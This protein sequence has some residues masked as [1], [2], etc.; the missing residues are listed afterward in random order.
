MNMFRN[1]AAAVAVDGDGELSE[2][3]DLIPLSHLALDLPEPSEGWLTFLGRRGIRFVSD[4]LGRDAIS[5]G[6][7]QRLLAEKREAELRKRQLAAQQ[8]AE[9]VLKDQQFRAS[10]PKGL[11]WYAFDGAPYG[12][13][14][15]AAEAAQQPRRTPSRGEWLFG[16]TDTMVFH[17][18]EGQEAEAS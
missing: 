4:R 6:D 12:E 17:S 8:E 16:E 18:M 15:A 5:A 7:V 3:A 2:S 11:P 14:V 10:L 1:S 9:A 13:V